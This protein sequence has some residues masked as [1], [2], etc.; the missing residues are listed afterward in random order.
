MTIEDQIK[1][2][3]E[4]L[5]RLKLRKKW[6]EQ[7]VEDCEALIRKSKYFLLALEVKSER[8]SA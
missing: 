3:R 7:D 6:L 8:Q 4:T 2:E 1:T 5:R